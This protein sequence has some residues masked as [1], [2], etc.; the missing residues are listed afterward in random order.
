MS[1][2]DF[3]TNKAGCSPSANDDGL[4][5]AGK[6][7]PIGLG[8]PIMKDRSPPHS[9]SKTTRTQKNTVDT[10]TTL[11]RLREYVHT[12]RMYVTY[13]VDKRRINVPP[14]RTGMYEMVRTLASKILSVV[15]YA[16]TRSQ[17]QFIDP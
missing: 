6:L 7:L 17:E 10:M 8:F 14:V 5:D 9:A 3:T 1:A 11:S 2:A 16:S 12:V 15:N 13:G 4:A